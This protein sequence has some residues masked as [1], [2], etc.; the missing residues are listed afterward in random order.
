MIL[1]PLDYA[2]GMMFAD[3][4]LLYKIAPTPHFYFILMNKSQM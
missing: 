3:N 4:L 1:D 2:L